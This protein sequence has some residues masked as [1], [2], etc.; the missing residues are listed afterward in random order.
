[1]INELNKISFSFTGE[2]IGLYDLLIQLYDLK[3]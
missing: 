1:M 3:N 2:T